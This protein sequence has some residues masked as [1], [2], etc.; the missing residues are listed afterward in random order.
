MSRTS[1]RRLSA[2]CVALTL[3]GA[4][5]TWSAVPAQAATTSVAVSEVYGGG[6]NAGAT[7]THDF[8][9]LYN[10]GDAPV[11]LATWSVEYYSATGSTASA[12]ALA[13]TLAPKSSY[14]VQL[15]AGAGGSTALPGP[16]A[17]GSTAVSASAGRVLLRDGA[18]TVDAVAYGSAATPVEGSP[19]PGTSSTTSATRSN[20]CTDTDDNAADFI[21][22]APSP[23]GSAAGSADCVIDPGPGD[24]ETIEQVQGAAHLAP[25]AGD[26]ANGVEGVVTAVGR[27][28]FWF[29]DPTPDA[30]PAT[31]PA[32]LVFTRT[33]PTVAVGDSVTVDGTV[34]EFRPG[35]TSGTNNLTTTQ[36]SSPVITV[37]ASGQPLP[38]P[39][40][41]GVD[42][43]APPQTIEQGDP[44]TVEGPTAPFRPDL[45]AIDFY[46]SLEGV[47][48]A[49]R[50]AQ[51]VGPT[52]SFGEIPVLPGNLAR[53]DAVRSGRGGVVYAGYDR[54]NAMR[55]QL[56]DA[57]LPAG[58]MP[59]A[60]VGDRLPG[61]TAGVLD[62]SFAN[63]KLAVT[64][65]P[66]VTA[67][68]LAR[69][70]TR[71]AGR[72]EL[73]VAT[74]NVENLAA[75]DPASKFERLADQVVTNLRAPDLLTLE[76][77][78][79]NSG[80][81][82]DGVVAADRTVSTLVAA[83]TAAG[84]PTYQ[85]RWI[86]PQNLTDGGQPGGNI[87]QVFLFRTDRGLTFVDRPG[88]DATTATQ[89]VTGGGG[90][91]VSLSP[92]RIDPANAAWTAS[93]KPLVGEFRYRGR[94]VFV[95]ANHFAS[96][97]GDNPL[98]GPR[99]QPVR[100]SES[101]RR[102]Q[103][104]AVRGF[105]D[106]LLAADPRAAVVVLGDINDFEFS[107]VTDVL[108]GTGATAF[109]DLPRTL[110]A[111]QRYTYVFEGNSQVLDHILISPGLAERRPWW[112]PRAFSYDIVHTNSE[113]P[114]Q[115]SD[116]D[117]QVVRL[118]IR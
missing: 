57:L 60:T 73:A 84:G 77:I 90:P 41:L 17:T 54:P 81:T 3:V 29:Q 115:D 70:V 22:A 53:A 13:G 117:P 65:P 69:E 31:S 101:A 48:V 4:A 83:I 50:D 62:Y 47:R 76:E 78:Q 95:I 20:P 88:G 34:T 61:D 56:D 107:A 37:G 6:G 89:V 1:Q 114:D 8:I 15:A 111:S 30:D 97:G 16:D 92:G 39:V 5:V 106:Q 103:A 2:G 45:D 68:G 27:S 11:D 110:P 51:V 55:V 59:A 82:N 86:D 35:G 87:R 80:A 108:V 66:T 52:S 36:L 64:A 104:T 33:A 46:E 72:G 100:S 94:P 96:K 118:R 98:F 42:R 49:V 102:D 67:G 99:Q 38:A 26:P 12:T 44:G 21:A 23:R 74:F 116:H 112:Q 105:A 93:R 43:T 91:S 28:G 24:P 75:S 32:V 71:P 109:L 63:Y 40:V 7:Y 10:L 25:L 9:E 113:F 79:D 58:A 18:R 85:A 19:A 14:L